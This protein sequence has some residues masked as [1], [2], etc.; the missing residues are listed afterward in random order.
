MNKRNKYRIYSERKDD[1]IDTECSM[2]GQKMLASEI[3]YLNILV[4]E[5]EKITVV[6]NKLMQ[7]DP[8]IKSIET[9]LDLDFEKELK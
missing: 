7:E 2:S 6:H 9:K 3:N 5:Y 4:Q 1:G 8:Q